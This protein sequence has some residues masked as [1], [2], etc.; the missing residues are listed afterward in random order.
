MLED[1]WVAEVELPIGVECVQVVHEHQVE[2]LGARLGKRVERLQAR[3]QP[4]ERIGDVL[5]RAAQAFGQHPEAF[6]RER[7]ED[8]VLAGEVAVNGCRA[9]FDATARTTL[10]TVVDVR[11]ETLYRL[12]S[13]TDGQE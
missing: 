2:V 7:E 11:P 5:H 4:I 9:V 10:V 13:G 12:A 6:F 8:V 1:D 3:A